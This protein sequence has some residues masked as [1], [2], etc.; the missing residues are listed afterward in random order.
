MQKEVID[1]LT[2]GKR[3]AIIITYLKQPMTAKQLAQVTGMRQDSCSYVLGELR[4][5]R[6]VY[7]MNPQARRSRLYWLRKKGRQYRKKILKMQRQAISADD[8]PDVDWKLYGWVC[9][10]H[11]AAV[12]QV[13]TEPLRPGT[14]RKKVKQQNPDMKI[15]ANNIADILHLFLEK[16]IIKPIKMRK[17]VHLRYK[18]TERGNN[19]R[20]LLHQAETIC[21]NRT[22]LSQGF[23]QRPI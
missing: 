21:K 20:I 6:M 4:T 3:R 22:G 9:F 17:K 10:T 5:Q 11:R 2:Q 16:R 19:L 1:W 13:L 12:I 15:S 14:I 8:L 7:C 23:N 18:L